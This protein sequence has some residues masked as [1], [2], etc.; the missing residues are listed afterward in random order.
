VQNFTKLRAVVHELLCWQRNKINLA[1]TLK[2]ILLLIQR[3]VINYTM[4]EALTATG[5]STRC[6][7]VDG[8][9]SLLL[10]CCTVCIT[11]RQHT[12][13]HRRQNHPWAWRILC[14]RRRCSF[15]KH[16]T[17]SH[18]LEHNQQKNNCNKLRK[19]INNS[20]KQIN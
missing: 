6:S 13:V 12:A 17:V 11:T 15:V 3:A 10:S 14:H 20:I 18:V 2:T 9:R 5:W 16:K 4:N 19:L 7:E 1:V 8:Y